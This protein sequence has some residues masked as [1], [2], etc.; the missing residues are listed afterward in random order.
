[1]TPDADSIGRMLDN[2]PDQTDF[3]ISKAMKLYNFIIHSAIISTSIVAASLPVRA[4]I[5][6]YTDRNAFLAAL[7]ISFT[8]TIII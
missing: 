5:V 2:P 8:D 1:M 3:K 7:S 6:T 4:E